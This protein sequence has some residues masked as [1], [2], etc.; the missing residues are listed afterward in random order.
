MTRE[1]QKKYG[2]PADTV[3][4]LRHH[5]EIQENPSF[6]KIL[7]DEGLKW[8]SSCWIKGNPSCGFHALDAQQNV[9]VDEEKVSLLG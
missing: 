8:K 7:I 5:T 3:S 2:L 6:T 1:F 4:C 9:C